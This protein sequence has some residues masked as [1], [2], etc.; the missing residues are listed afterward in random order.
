MAE[1]VCLNQTKGRLGDHRIEG[2][3]RDTLEEPSYLGQ[4]VCVP[5]THN[6]FHRAH[7][8]DEDS[9]SRLLRRHKG[10]AVGM[11]SLRIDQDVRV[12]PSDREPR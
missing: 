6:Q 3:D 9:R 4:L 7:G 2:D 8:A 1:K 5:A 10:D 11:T 12:D